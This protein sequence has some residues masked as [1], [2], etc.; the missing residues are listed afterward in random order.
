MKVFRY[1]N[2]NN[3]HGHYFIVLWFVILG[4]IPFKSSLM[5]TLKQ[6]NYI[7]LEPIT[8]IWDQVFTV[9]PLV[10][11]GTKEKQGYDLAPKHMAMPLGFGNYFGFV[12][13]PRHN[14]FDNILATG[15]FTVS[16]PLPDQIISTSLSASPRTECISKSEGIINSLPILRAPSM[17]APIIADAY[18]YLECEL[19]KIIDGFDDYSIITG[20]IKAAYAH[21]DY[22]K[23]SEIDEQQQLAKNPLLAYIAPGRFA[24]ISATNGFPFPKNFQR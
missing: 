3:D 7:L 4:I 15:Q 17:D 6:D 5:N 22:M 2:I 23:V 11:I 20:R 1:G 8:S 21:K 10:V 12:C 24:K 9:A 18:F 16:F 13:T 14:T 19:Y